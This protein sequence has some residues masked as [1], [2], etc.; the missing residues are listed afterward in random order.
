[1]TLVRTSHLLERR[2]H[3][4]IPVLSEGQK[5]M[6]ALLS[7]SQ[8]TMSDWKMAAFTVAA[9]LVVTRLSALFRNTFPLLRGASV[10]E[11]LPQVAGLSWFTRSPALNRVGVG[12][13]G[14]SLFL[15]GCGDANPV[16][17]AQLTAPRTLEAQ[18]AEFSV[19]AELSPG[20]Q[21]GFAASLNVQGQLAVTWAD[22]NPSQSNPS[23]V[24][25]RTFSPNGI[26][27]AVTEIERPQGSVCLAPSLSN[28]DR[29]N[30]LAAWTQS[31]GPDAPSGLRARRYNSQ[32]QAQGNSFQIVPNEN[33]MPTIVGRVALN[34]DAS[35]LVVSNENSRDCGVCVRNYGAD[36]LQRSVQT[37]SEANLSVLSTDL[38][39]S[40]QGDWAWAA[41]LADNTGGR[42]LRFRYYHA[43][44][45]FGPAVT[46][47]ISNP[48]T[49]T[50]IKVAALPNDRAIVVWQSAQG[51]RARIFKADGS[52]VGA[53]IALNALP[54]GASFSATSDQNGAFVVAWEDAGQKQI[55]ASLIAADGRIIS[56][57]MNVSENSTENQEV[58]V[59]GN[60]NG[61]ITFVWQRFQPSP[62][63]YRLVARNYQVRY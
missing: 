28:D 59:T 35:F 4:E 44:V 48:G 13:L 20:T 2:S 57:N 6:D 31:M 45:G 46:A 42:S 22:L 50:Q 23:T 39:P 43:G 51:L 60:E 16:T 41:L 18:G 63:G 40:A 49:G 53:E 47:P 9:P 62:A 1:M 30:I 5:E 17:D 21:Q 24:N 54:P 12:A 32:G 58:R 36:N 25:L 27:G 15:V 26:P 3:F 52:G 61:R 33:H 10:S 38:A 56:G 29:G 11:A 19:T 14:G 55:R 34:E 37:L 7:T 8:S